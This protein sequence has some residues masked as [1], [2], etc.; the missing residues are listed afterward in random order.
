MAQNAKIALSVGMAWT[1]RLIW[2]IRVLWGAKNAGN[3]Q[4]T[5]RLSGS[6]KRRVFEGMKQIWGLGSGRNEKSDPENPNFE[7]GVKRLNGE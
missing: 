3:E 4:G 7:F 1:G 5:I 2:W 6:L